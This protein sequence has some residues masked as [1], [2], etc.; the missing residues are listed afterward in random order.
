MGIREV[1]CEWAMRDFRGEGAWNSQGQ[2]MQCQ[3]GCR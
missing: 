3:E 2:E 1:N